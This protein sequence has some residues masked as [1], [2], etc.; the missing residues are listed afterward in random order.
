MSGGISAATVLS[1]VA[2]AATVYSSMQQSKAAKKAANQQSAPPIQ[3]AAPPPQ[4]SRA[5]DANAYNA[6]NAQAAMMGPT[7]GASSTLLTGAGGIDPGA[8]NLGKNTLLGS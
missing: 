2:T 7:A 1:A 6:K 3:Q 4:A 8:F 5:P